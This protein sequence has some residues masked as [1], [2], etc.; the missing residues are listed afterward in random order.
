M[1]KKQISNKI[2]IVL[3]GESNSGGISPNS[4][5]VSSEL[6]PRNVKILN[7]SSL[8]FEPL[9]IG[10][11]NL[12]NHYGLES[13]WYDCHGM[14]LEIANK[15][16]EGFFGGKEVFIVKAGIGGS[17]VSQWQ[18]GGTFSGQNSFENF[19][20]RVSKAIELL[21][22]PEVV[23]ML[24]IGINDK[25]ASTAAETYKSGLKTIIQNIQSYY[26]LP[27][28]LSLMKFQFVTS[29]AANCYATQID[30]VATELGMK[31]FSTAGCAVLPDGNHLTYSGM[32][33]ATDNF[34][35]SL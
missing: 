29:A 9:D 33:A 21:D 13:Y 10:S 7:N 24:S 3:L 26:A 11:N 28:K 4:S 22:N 6:L 1:Q 31:T 30:E 14:E 20:T 27:F 32:K 34:L 25:L 2:L 16:D 8:V 23:F 5:A 12:I 15:Y 35:N 18:I 17:K 19:K